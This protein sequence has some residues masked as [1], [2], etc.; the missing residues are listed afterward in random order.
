MYLWL[1][2]CWAVHW[3]ISWSKTCNSGGLQSCSREMLPY[4]PPWLTV[5]FLSTFPSIFYLAVTIIFGKNPDKI[6]LLVCSK[7]SSGFFDLILTTGLHLFQPHTITLGSFQLPGLCTYCSVC[8]KSSS[9]DFCH[10]YFHFI[11]LLLKHHSRKLTIF[12]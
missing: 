5:Y 1:F 8:F 11:R 4:W 2:L 9:H 6:T 3:R 7:P 12:L 10:L